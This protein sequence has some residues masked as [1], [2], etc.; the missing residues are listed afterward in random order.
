MSFQGFPS[1]TSSLSFWR[2]SPSRGAILHGVCLFHTFVPHPLQAGNV[3]DSLEILTSNTR[4]QAHLTSGFAKSRTCNPQRTCRKNTFK[5][6]CQKQDMGEGKQRGG[7][8]REGTSTH[9]QVACYYTYVY[10]RPSNCM[11]GLFLE[12]LGTE[13]RVLC[14]PGKC[15][16]T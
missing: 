1:F 15:S 11:H 16:S 6:P 5:K 2:L 4:D 8:G 13:L 9:G 7:E 10:V 3:H 12:T 14:T